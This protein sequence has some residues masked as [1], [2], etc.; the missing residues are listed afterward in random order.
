MSET[1]FQITVVD[2]SSKDAKWCFEQYYAELGR[3]FE[4][5]FDPALSISAHMHELM[6]PAGLLVVAYL[7]REPVG[8][9]ALKFHSDGVGEIKRMWVSTNVRGR[10]L[11]KKLLMALEDSARKAGISVLHLETNKSLVEAIKLYR[12]SGYREVEA[13]NEEPYAH[14]W[15]EKR[16]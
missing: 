15:F 16:L 4:R 9:G 2:P 8:C 6:P 5:G 13:F 10:G 12:K 11:G 1:D 3:R 14:H 7:G